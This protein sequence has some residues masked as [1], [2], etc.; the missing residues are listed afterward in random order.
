[1]GIFSLSFVFYC[2]DSAFECFNSFHEAVDGFVMA[3]TMVDKFVQ[4]FLQFSS[5]FFFNQINQQGMDV[6]Y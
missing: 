5:G 1:M 6:F 2:F 3:V 4:E